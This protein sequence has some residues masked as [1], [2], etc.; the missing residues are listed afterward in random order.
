MLIEKHGLVVREIVPA[1]ETFLV[2]WL[3]TPSVLEFYEGRDRT[4]NLQRVREKFLNRNDGV[5]RHIVAFENHPIGYIQY[6][7]V[8]SSNPIYDQ[9][10]A[11]ETVYGIDQFIGEPSYW[12]KGLGTTLVKI[13]TS[14]LTNV[15]N[16]DRVIL[17]PQV[18]NL[19]AIKCYE[20]CGFRKILRLPK[21]EYHEG[22]YRDCWL[23][24]FEK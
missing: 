9:K 6:Y 11:D 8:V 2:K 17:D 24:T 15:M 19:R 5:K 16:A 21:H 23:M 20:K 7:S 22:A 4:F 3:S 18:T 12:N 14:Y 1:D 10:W 13:M